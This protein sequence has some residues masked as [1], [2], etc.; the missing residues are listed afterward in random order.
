[1]VSMDQLAYMSSSAR[2]SRELIDSF[3]YGNRS[4]RLFLALYVLND[5]RHAVSNFGRLLL[6]A[7]DD[8]DAELTRALLLVLPTLTDWTPAQ[9]EEAEKTAQ[10]FVHHADTQVKVAAAR[11]LAKV[12]SLEYFTERFS[13]SEIRELSDQVFDSMISGM[14]G[15][16]AKGRSMSDDMSLLVANSVLLR[17][18]DISWQTRHAFLGFLENNENFDQFAR[19]TCAMIFPAEGRD[20]C[21]KWVDDTALRKLALRVL[22][23]TDAPTLSE[24]VAVPRASYDHM[25]MPLAK[26]ILSRPTWHAFA[27]ARHSDV[28]ERMRGYYWHPH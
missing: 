28:G 20:M 12:G 1:M 26:D 17:I 23:R 10:R 27:L 16:G 3:R 21:T 8:R 22:G 9:M 13:V 15:V 18:G 5:G 19:K 11:A 4:E 6:T 25:V 14:I 7:M 24:Y 2:S